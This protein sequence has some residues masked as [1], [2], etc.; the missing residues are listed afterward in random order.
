MRVPGEERIE[1]SGSTLLCGGADLN[2]CGRVEFCWEDRARAAP[3]TTRRFAVVLAG[4]LLRPSQ[5]LPCNTVA[6]SS[7]FFLTKHDSTS[8]SH[9]NWADSK[10]QGIASGDVCVTREKAQ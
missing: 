2:L 6:G 7:S 8:L 3:R 5:F 10:W 9:L 4:F 1:R